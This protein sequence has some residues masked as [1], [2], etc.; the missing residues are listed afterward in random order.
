M[1]FKLVGNKLP[2]ESRDVL[3]YHSHSSS[4][5]SLFFCE[6]SRKNVNGIFIKEVLEKNKTISLPAFSVMFI[7]PVVCLLFVWA[8]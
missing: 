8:L 5:H 4:H 7:N 1:G 6:F 3:I 2:K